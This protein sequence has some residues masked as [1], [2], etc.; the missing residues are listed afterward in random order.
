MGK[1]VF[2]NVEPVYTPMQQCMSEP[3]SAQ[4]LFPPTL[5]SFYITTSL[6]TT[7]TLYCLWENAD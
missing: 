1:L 4:L 7:L 3:V 2:K 5:L 6:N